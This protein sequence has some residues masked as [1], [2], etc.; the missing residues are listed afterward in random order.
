MK[1]NTQIVLAYWK[2]CGLPLATP[3]Y[4][5]HPERKF[6]FDFAFVDQ[7]VALEVEGAVWTHGGHSRGSGVVKDM[8]KYN[9]AAILGWRLLRVTPEYVCMMSTVELIKRA[10][11]KV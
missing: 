2:Q 11:D 1:Y 9:E 5:F 3:E 6:R 7:K 10:L 8:E 4:K